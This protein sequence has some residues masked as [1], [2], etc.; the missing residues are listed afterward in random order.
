M[1]NFQKLS[2]EYRRILEE[3]ILRWWL[4]HAVDHEHGGVLSCIKDNGSVV[5]D[6]KYVWSQT[7]ALWTFSAAFNRI[8]PNP[9]YMAVADRLF[10]FLVKY[11]RNEHGRWRYLLSRQGD[12]KQDATSI[13]TDAFAIC[14]L[15]EYARA[16]KRQEPV[17]LARQTY[18]CVLHHLRNPGSYETTPYPL[19]EGTKAQRVSMQFSLAF[20]EL[21]KLLNDQDILSQGMAL[22]DDVLDHF[23][24]PDQQAIVEYL[25]LDNS[26]LP[27]PFGT[28]MG[29][30]HGIETAWFQLENI[31]HLQETE[32]KHKAIEVMQW[33]LERGWDQ[34]YGG[35][36]LHVDLAGGE[37]LLPHANKKLSWVHSEALCGLPMAYEACG[38]SWTIEWHQRITDWTFRSFPNPEHGEWHH[39]LDRQGQPVEE[40][41]AL[42]VKDPFHIPRGLIY[43]V[44]TFD[45]L[46]RRDGH[47]QQPPEL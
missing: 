11:G 20:W 9:T 47:T 2:S 19:P 23:R 5:S 16:T 3:D 44:E 46:S 35:L 18:Q 43:A 37:P 7:R 33:S 17:D 1:I 32:R 41:I 40:V 8:H 34:N 4:R 24:Q 25:S 29:P 6:D 13:Q 42:P 28:L 45:R 21:G 26:C 12:C 30:G 39:R 22:T 10:E 31:R 36:F 38:E 14:G 15:V 27:A